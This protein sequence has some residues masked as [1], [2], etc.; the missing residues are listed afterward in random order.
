M[1]D[2][3]KFLT[4]LHSCWKGSTYNNEWNGSSR[5]T[6]SKLKGFLRRLFVMNLR[7]FIYCFRIL[8]NSIFFPINSYF[9]RKSFFIIDF[10]H[11]LSTFS[12]HWRYLHHKWDTTRYWINRCNLQWCL[13]VNEHSSP[14]PFANKNWTKKMGEK[15]FTRKI[16]LNWKNAWRNGWESIR[17]TNL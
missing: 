13:K 12:Q 3:S 17:R 5:K 8:W 10:L 11:L 15:D 16:G 14:T 9:E 2:F 7:S 1:S 4:A 6:K